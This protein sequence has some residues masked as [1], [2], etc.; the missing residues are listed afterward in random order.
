MNQPDSSVSVTAGDDVILSCS[1]PPQSPK[2]I[3]SW[4]KDA[5]PEPQLIYSFNGSQF[6]RVTQVKKK[7]ANQADYSIR[8]S[9]VSPKDVGT[10][11]CVKLKKGDHDVKLRSGP[12]TYVSIKGSKE[13]VSQVQQNEMSQTVST[14][15][16]VTLSCTVPDTLPSG[17]VAWFKGSGPNRKLIFNFKDD[18]FPRV[19]ATADT[20]KAGNTDFS[21]R[22]SEVSLA[23]A[24]TYYCVKFKNGKP[25]EYQS[26]QGSQVFVT[27]TV[28]W[29]KEDG[30][31]RQLIY[32]FNGNHFP[33]VT[34]VQKTVPN[35]MD[36]SIRISDMSPKDA[37][38]Y[39]CVLLKKGNPAMELM[40]GPGTY[41]SV[42]GE[43]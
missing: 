40:S 25:N 36:Y 3:V 35:Q 29:F 34:Q 38:T 12:G 14:G 32:S 28:S 22:I 19:K 27:G 1:M 33:R 23:D 6:P 5:E 39:F 41:V 15:E 18:R 43:P 2:G 20:S 42:K 16:T 30:P 10:Y 7:N 13:E 37:G 21:I 24:G 17:P 8:I 4:F 31:K 11:Y 26:G 9:N